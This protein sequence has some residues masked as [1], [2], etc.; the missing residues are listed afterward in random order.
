MDGRI[1]NGGAREN[2]GRKSMEEEALN[3]IKKRNAEE[4]AS[5]KITKH[6]EIMDEKDRD[7]I[8]K[9]AL[10]VYLKSKD[11]PIGDKANPFVVQQILTDENFERLHNAYEVNKRGKN[12]DGKEIL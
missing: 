10:P 3:I 9:V 1:N 12:I 11:K 5:D 4:V 8:T 6:L 2:A 7:G